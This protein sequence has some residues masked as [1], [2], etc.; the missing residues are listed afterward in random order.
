[1]VVALLVPAGTAFACP[2]PKPEA[3]AWAYADADAGGSIT[4]VNDG[5]DIKAGS[6]PFW[7]T[8][9]PWGTYCGGAGGYA[10]TKGQ[11]GV[12]VVAAKTGGFAVAG[13]RILDEKWNVIEEDYDFAASG[14]AKLDI[15]VSTKGGAKAFAKVKEGGE[16]GVYREVQWFPEKEGTYHIQ[17]FSGAAD[18][19]EAESWVKQFRG[20][21]AWDLAWDADKECWYTWL[22]FT[23]FPDY[24][25][26]II[27]IPDA[28]VDWVYVVEWMDDGRTEWKNDWQGGTGGMPTLTLQPGWYFIQ[29]NTKDGWGSKWALIYVTP[30][31]H[32]TL[33]GRALY[34]VDG[35]VPV[36]LFETRADV[37]AYI[38][39]AL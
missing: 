36:M 3:E 31:M 15:D 28:K 9:Y 21:E 19:S 14:E 12:A 20:K 23:I 34:D 8:I 30:K 39:H 2:P 11:P 16:A 29:L 4:G 35:V 37:E 18:R 10:S 1:M 27:Q 13:Y 6:K 38:G 7:I 26:G 5:Q 24:V 33:A 32:L 25:A 22:T 17:A